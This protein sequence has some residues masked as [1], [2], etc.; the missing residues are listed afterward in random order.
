MKDKNSSLE[1]RDSTLSDDSFI[2]SPDGDLNDTVKSTPS[3]LNGLAQVPKKQKPS[4][5]CY[6]MKTLDVKSVKV[7][8]K[9]NDL[10]SISW[11]S[12]EHMF[13]QHFIKSGTI[14]CRLL[15]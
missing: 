4:M 8:K 11:L 6:A 5:L 10:D 9:G 15:R 7:S 2:T 12:I 3:T 13:R 1:P 14:D